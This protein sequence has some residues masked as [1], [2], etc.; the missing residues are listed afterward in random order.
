[1]N[2]KKNYHNKKTLREHNTKK[3]AKRETQRTISTQKAVLW[4]PSQKQLLK[5]KSIEHKPIGKRTQ[6][7]EKNYPGEKRT[8]P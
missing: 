4:K 3:L 2:K 7:Q 5:S 1:M 6:P 8:E